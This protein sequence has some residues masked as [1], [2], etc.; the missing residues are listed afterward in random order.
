MEERPGHCIKVA[1]TRDALQLPPLLATGMTIGA[2]VPTAKPAVL[3]AIRVGTE[4]RMRID[5]PPTASAKVYD[6]RW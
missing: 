6:G 2:D 3:R 4:V 1:M 5:R